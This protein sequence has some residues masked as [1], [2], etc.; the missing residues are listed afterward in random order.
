MNDVV[1]MLLCERK[2]ETHLTCDIGFMSSAISIE[3]IQC[4]NCA[5]LRLEFNI[6][7]VVTQH[8]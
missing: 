3:R 5:I 7:I 6:E 2:S 1:V 8:P 4:D